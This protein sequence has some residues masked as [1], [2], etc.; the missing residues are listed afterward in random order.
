MFRR[1][2][3]TMGVQ[4]LLAAIFMQAFRIRAL[5]L[6]LVFSGCVSS[7]ARARYDAMPFA[8]QQRWRRCANNVVRVQCGVES[9]KDAIYRSVCGSNLAES[10]TLQ[11]TTASRI[12]WL[13]GY[14]CPPAM[15]EP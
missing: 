2:T 3:R 1:E 12:R 5:V 10:Y 8:D 7:A 4:Q 11:P 9:D 13:R 6:A 15:V 14:G